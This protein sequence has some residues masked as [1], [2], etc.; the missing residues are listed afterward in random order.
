[1]GVNNVTLSL[2]AGEVLGLVGANGAGK[3]TTTRA[4][5]GFL[6]SEGTRVINGNVEFNGESITNLEPQECSA[7]GIALVP[8]RT[9]IFPNLSVLDNLRAIG[10][11][12]RRG[13][14]K[15]YWDQV[16]DLF[17]VLHERLSQPAGQLSGGERQ[18]L[19]LARALANRPQ[20]LIVDE[21]T[22]GIHVSIHQRLYTI[23]KTI[24]AEGVA[25][26]VVDERAPQILEI[27]DQCVILRAGRVAAAGPADEFSSLNL[28][29]AEYVGAAT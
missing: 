18:M 3:S 22:L 9:K 19:G 8:E 20:L 24:A 11:S 5:S 16:F 1:M 14:R 15:H 27:S 26:I 29:T 23:L 10:K 13:D 12:P 6:R 17:P 28:M 7:R 25:V 4:M 21:L 2:K